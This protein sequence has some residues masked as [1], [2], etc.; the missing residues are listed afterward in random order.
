MELYYWLMA[1]RPPEDIFFTHGDYCQPNIFIDGT[2]VTGFIDVGSG[3]IADRWQDIAL[4]VRSLG[5][6]LG[7]IEKAKK[8]KYINLL[9]SHLGID[10]DWVKINYYI[11]LDELF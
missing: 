4:C 8:E 10:P 6:N 5:Y 11:L 1:N 3:G 9:F 2:K 7:E